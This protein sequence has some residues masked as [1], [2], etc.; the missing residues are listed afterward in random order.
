MPYVYT[1]QGIAMLSAVLRSDIAVQVSIN[2]MKTFV[3]MRKYLAHNSL[4]P[5]KMNEMEQ[6]QLKTDLQY[7]TFK[8]ETNER[9][10]RI[11]EYIETHKE[12]YQKIFFA[13]QIFD[14]FTLMTNLVLQANKTIILI[15]GYVDIANFNAQYPRLSV[16]Y[17]TA[18][19][20]RFMIIDETEGYHIG[21]SIK[22]A[23]KRC[24]GINKIEDADIIKDLLQR[25]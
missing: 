11:F 12:E 9:F 13:G 18:F 5:E 22:D 4:I 20:D 16:R 15:D 8:K 3:E 21:A 14:A 2:I 17:T 24:F 1:E 10:E 25:A 19:H 6:H 7:E 23:G